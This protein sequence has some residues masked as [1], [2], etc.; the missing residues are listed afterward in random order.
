MSQVLLVCIGDGDDIGNVIDF[1]LL[2]GDLDNAS[3][4]CF[5]VK[6]SIEKIAKNVQAEMAASLVYAAGDDICF[7]V[8]T[9]NFISEK[10]QSYSNIFFEET[11]KTISFGVARTSAEAAMCLRRAKV[12]GK[13]CIVISGAKI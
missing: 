4:F 9:N 10:L 13:G 1:Y 2:S 12:S 5:Q 6:A 7:I 8:S 11:G 3:K